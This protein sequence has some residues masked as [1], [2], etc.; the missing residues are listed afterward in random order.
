[1]AGN[2]MYVR[3][4]VETFLWGVY[5]TIFVFTLYIL[6]TRPRSRTHK[7]LF[8]ATILM[9]C[10]ASVHVFLAAKLGDMSNLPTSLD[11]VSFPLLVK[12][13]GNS[14]L[15]MRYLP[16][17]SFIFGDGIVAWRAWV[18]CGKSLRILI[19]PGLLLLATAAIVLANL[20]TGLSNS[21][22]RNFAL[23]I[24]SVALTL[25]NNILLTSLIGLCVW[26]RR[27]HGVVSIAN[28]KVGKD[29]TGAAL[30]LL[31]ESGAL[32]CILWIGHL[33]AEAIV[34]PGT[35]HPLGNMYLVLD[36]VVPQMVGLYPTAVIALAAL[37]RAHYESQEYDSSPQITLK[38][39]T[40][41]S[42]RATV[43]TFAASESV[44]N[45]SAHPA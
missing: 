39:D 7:V 18:I 32:Y 14:V 31:F 8:G 34:Q 27:R 2:P 35:D 23:Y 30:L 41:G 6:F 17:V 37:Q 21:S 25:A 10:I 33:V 42:P 24:T 38:L 13:G 12:L 15:V 9:Y 28:I 22:P 45:I 11:Q 3:Q 26:T 20:V 36:G 19:V 43:Q 5:T 29:R 4:F 44:T 40:P 1:M 16:P